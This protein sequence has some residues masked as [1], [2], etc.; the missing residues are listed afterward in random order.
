MSCYD[1]IR[2]FIDASYDYYSVV[3]DERESWLDCT[4]SQNP[5]DCRKQQM[6]APKIKT[7]YKAMLLAEKNAHEIC[8]F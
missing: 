6:L 8:R 4:D 7:T 5:W 3:R 2:M 1:A